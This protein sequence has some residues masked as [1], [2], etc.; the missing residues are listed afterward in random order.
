MT[1]DD[2]LYGRLR[3]WQPEAGP[4]VNMDTV[5]LA[6]WVRRPPRGRSSFVELGAAAGAVSLMLALRFSEEFRIVGVELQPDLA[7]MAERNG[8]ENGLETRVSFRCGDLRDPS[9]IGRAHV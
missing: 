2:I 4:R 3:L 5:L 6:S 8:R 1:H 7:A 9:Q